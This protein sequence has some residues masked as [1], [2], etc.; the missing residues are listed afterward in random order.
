M[1]KYLIKFKVIKTNEIDIIIT[2]GNK[3]DTI[4]FAEEVKREYYKEKA[5]IAEITKIR[6]F[7]FIKEEY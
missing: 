3:K 5:E 2:M 4:K 1:E 6:D 7:D